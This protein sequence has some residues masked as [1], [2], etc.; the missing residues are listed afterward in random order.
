MSIASLLWL[1]AP[2]PTLSGQDAGSAPKAN[3]PFTD[4]AP[5]LQVLREDLWP[6]E[7]RGRT[8]DDIQA[9]WP[10]WVSR[11][12]TAIR[13]RVLEG[14]E[15]SI[16]NLLVFGTSFT[17]QPRVTETE[18][19]GVLVRQAGT[20]AT[21]FVAS[22][23]LEARI[24]DFVAAVASPGTNERLQFARRVIDRRGLNATTEQGKR[25]LR[26]YLEERESVVGSA[27][28]AQMLNDPNTALADQLTLF[29]DRGLASDTSIWIDFAVERALDDLRTEGLLEPSAVRRVAIVGPGLDFA[30]KQEGYD[31]YPQQTIQ[32][33]ALVDSLIRLGLASAA[34]I[35]VTAFD[36]SPR[37][38]QHLEAARER[39]RGGASYSLVLPRKLDQS[40]GPDVAK[41]W[42]RFGDRIGVSANAAPPPSSA[43]P[44]TARSVLVR[45]SV[46]LSLMPR[47]LNIVVQRLDP[48]AAGEQFD[49]VL[50]TNIL[51]YYDV[52][53]QSLAVTNIAKMLR[54]GGLF[55]S[56]DRVFELP[57]G[58]VDAVGFTDVRYTTQAGAAGKGDRITWY[59]RR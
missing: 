59:R 16:I 23:L 34:D 28:H 52:F 20:G 13:A 2:A 56:N 4:A 33:F 15:D 10:A 26:Q 49:L 29:K 30:D 47:D 32:P 48:M 57:A 11:R 53:E 6:A 27:V 17:R 39:A 19:A 43:G 41:Y 55:L 31:F 12:D 1:V 35:Q 18:L 42:E 25:A 46:A 22:P 7:L 36:L 14:D 8:P 40:W 9:G 3:T 5:I 50:A 38:L 58:P 51:L 21:A 54:P 37:V 24:D 44:V 45:P